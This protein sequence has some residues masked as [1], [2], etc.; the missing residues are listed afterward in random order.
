M[1]NFQRVACNGISAVTHRPLRLGSR[2]FCRQSIFVYTA[3]SEKRPKMVAFSWRQRPLPSENIFVR[4][5]TCVIT[6]K[7]HRT[8]QFWWLWRRTSLVGEPFQPRY[9]RKRLFSNDKSAIQINSYLHCH[10]NAIKIYARMWFMQ[11]RGLCS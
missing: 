3:P 2:T 5:N 9:G 11:M 4:R 10:V 8:G 7:G 6:V 1:Q